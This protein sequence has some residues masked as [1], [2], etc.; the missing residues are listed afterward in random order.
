MGRVWPQVPL[1][2]ELAKRHPRKLARLADAMDRIE[3]AEGDTIIRQDEEVRF[4]PISI[5]FNPI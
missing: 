5:R 3:Y 1:F 4:N 2:S